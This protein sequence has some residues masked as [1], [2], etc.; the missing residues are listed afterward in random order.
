[1]P[2]CARCL[3]L[4]LGVSFGFGISIFIRV[5]IDKNIHKKF[6]IPLVIGYLPLAIDGTGQ[7]VGLWHSTNILRVLT[8]TFAGSA[9]GIIFGMA[10][11]VVSIALISYQ[12]RHR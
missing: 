11:D 3:G 10:I 5:K 1:M 4:F 12:N 6:L 7:L 8:G 2:V 9:F